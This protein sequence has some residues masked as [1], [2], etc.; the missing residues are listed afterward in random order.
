VRLRTGVVLDRTQGALPRML[1]PFRFFA[2][3]PIA[4]G[5]QYMS[6]I[7]LDDWVALVQWAIENQQ[8]DGAINA[9]APEP[10]T[11][12]RF[13]HTVGS[14]LGRPAF[15]RVPALAVRL[16]LGEMADA[17]VVGGQRVVPKRALDL[18]F[19][20]RYPDL[21]GALDAVLTRQPAGAAPR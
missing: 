2:G 13:S 10:V 19:R 5:R 11:N 12:E 8:A 9:T 3:G 18:G 6:W 1:L 21:R 15:M 14:V 16:L 20:F 17:L 4:S 7:H